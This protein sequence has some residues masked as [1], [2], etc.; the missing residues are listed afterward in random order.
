MIDP[1]KLISVINDMVRDKHVME[2]GELIHP[3]GT[4]SYK[5]KLVSKN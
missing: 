3:N 5:F 4:Y 1:E 2:S